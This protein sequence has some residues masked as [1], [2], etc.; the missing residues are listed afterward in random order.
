MFATHN[1]GNVC[2]GKTW[3]VLPYFNDTWVLPQPP[4][5]LSVGPDETESKKTDLRSS[6]TTGNL[7]DIV[8]LKE[9]MKNI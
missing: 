6:I 2:N 8:L 3:G 1:R 7:E 9:H 4:R 5:R